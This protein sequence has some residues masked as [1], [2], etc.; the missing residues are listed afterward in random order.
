MLTGMPQGMQ[1][2]AG[3]FYDGFSV[4]MAQIGTGD[5]GALDDADHVALGEAIDDG[6]GQKVMLHE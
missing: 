3:L 1:L 2:A 4:H 5:V 6:Q